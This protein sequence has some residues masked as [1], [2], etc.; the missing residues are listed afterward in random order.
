MRPHDHVAG[1]DH[2][3]PPTTHLPFRSRRRRHPRRHPAAG[4]LP[5][6]GKP[7]P[8]PRQAHDGVQRLAEGEGRTRQDARER[9]SHGRFTISGARSAPALP[10]S[11]SPRSSSRSSSTT[12]AAERCR[13]SRRSTTAT[14][15]WTE[16][17]AAIAAWEAKLASAG[18]SLIRLL[19]ASWFPGERRRSLSLGSGR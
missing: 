6:P 4:R 18:D 1:G 11:A 3:E 16:M 2:Q 7:R 8:C 14:A 12:S 13:R 5:F 15:T 10:H 17:R 9:R 19:P